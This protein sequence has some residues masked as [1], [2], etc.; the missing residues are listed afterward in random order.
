MINSI[1]F[2]CYCFKY[3]SYLKNVTFVFLLVQVRIHYEESYLQK[4]YT[5]M[6]SL[7]E[8][9]NIKT[10]SLLETSY[11]VT[12]INTISIDQLLLFYCKVTNKK[13]KSN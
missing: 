1:S 10:N 8:L 7:E 11:P 5:C 6:Y 2:Q 12:M 9:L 4:A 3:D 13:E